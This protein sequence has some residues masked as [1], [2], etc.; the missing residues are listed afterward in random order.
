MINKWENTVRYYGQVTKSAVSSKGA[1]IQVLIDPL[2][3]ALDPINDHG[4]FHLTAFDFLTKLNRQIACTGIDPGLEYPN[5]HFE[6]VKQSI[7]HSDPEPNWYIYHSVH[8][9]SSAFLT[10]AAGDPTQHLQYMPFGESFIEQ[11]S[12]TSYYTPYTFSAK[13]RDTE[14]GYSYFGARYYDADISVWLSVDPMADKYPS[15]SA[16]MYC[17]GNPVILVDP[18]GREIIIPYKEKKGLG[19]LFER[20]KYYTYKLGEA[21]N[22]DNKFV[23][24]TVEALNYIYQNGADIGNVIK[25]I[26]EDKNNSIQIKRGTNFSNNTGPYYSRKSKSIEWPPLLGMPTTDEN[27]KKSGYQSPALSLFHE[28]VH[29]FID[30]YGYNNRTYD[31]LDKQIVVN[32]DFPNMLEKV[33][34]QNFETEAARV[35]QSKGN[36]ESTRNNWLGGGTRVKTSTSIK[37]L[38]TR[39]NNTNKADG[40]NE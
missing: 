25:T 16:Y 37:E 10:D 23:K 19:R 12:I 21:Y 39:N 24:Q 29:A 35:L 13:E 3:S 18:D 11:R 33:I 4:N 22:G 32:E 17:A 9:G 1:V 30:L 7:H 40:N 8:L 20:K 6:S 2:C 14:T 27:G 28:L 38:K 26:A 5:E 36:N 15:M 31:D 34:I